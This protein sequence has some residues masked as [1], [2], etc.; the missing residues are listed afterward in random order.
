MT[1]IAV[2][3]R[4]TQSETATSLPVFVLKGRKVIS[5]FKNI[6]LVFEVIQ[7]N[8]IFCS[9]S[10]TDAKFSPILCRYLLIVA[11]LEAFRVK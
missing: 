10:N 7:N 5:L 9:L 2:A 6:L 8:S 11:N 3:H 4:S 1:N